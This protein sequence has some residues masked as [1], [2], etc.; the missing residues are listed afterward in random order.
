MLQPPH[1]TPP[2]DLENLLA[3]SSKP[4][5]IGFGSIVLDNPDRMVRIILILCA[6]EVSGLSCQSSWSELAGSADDNVDWIGDCPHEWLFQHLAAVV[7]YGGAGTTTRGLKNG[8]STT[9]VPLFGE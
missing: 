2:S 7:H 9:I 5:Y 4:V 3:S 8:M 1:H 6:F